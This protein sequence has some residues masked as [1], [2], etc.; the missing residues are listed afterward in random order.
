MKSRL[1]NLVMLF[2]LLLAACMPAAA[3]VPA[4]LQ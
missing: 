1:F 2:S 3:P 4:L